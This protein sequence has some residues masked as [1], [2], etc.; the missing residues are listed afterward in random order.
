MSEAKGVTCTI[1]GQTVQTRPGETALSAAKRYGIEI[2]T[3]C[4]H[5]AVSPSGACRMCLVEVTW[6][7]RSKLV[8]SCIYIPWE[9]DVIQT[10]T[11]RVRAARRLVLELLLARC[12]DVEQVQEL[13]REYGVTGHRFDLAGC[14]DNE[15]CIL[16][17]LCVRVCAE[18]IGQH[19]IGFKQRGHERAIS[20]PFGRQAEECIG[21]GA[22]VFICPTGAL[23]YEDIGGER[24]M[25][26]LKTRMPLAVC[27]VCGEE[28]ATE[29]QLACIQE[30]LNI[31]EELAA[32]CPKCRGREFRVT[33][34]KCLVAKRNT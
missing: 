2:P 16:C 11:E 12:P 7:K 10:N 23:H 21:C 24:V 25:Q 20:T 30:R 19:A 31:P 33:L 9:D 18:V 5:D 27:R 8:T 15:R 6:G 29:K 26:E 1:D 17:G 13:A 3:L 4:H 28:F 34:E 22:C 14:E 32:T